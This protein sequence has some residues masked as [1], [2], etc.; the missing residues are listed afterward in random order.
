M[1]NQSGVNDIFENEGGGNKTKTILL[2]SIVAVILVVAFLIIAWVITREDTIE[3]IDAI[4]DSQ[5][6]RVI[7]QPSY[8]SNTG[9]SVQQYPPPYGGS[10]PLDINMSGISGTPPPSIP[11]L[12]PPSSSTDTDTLND[13][14]IIDTMRQIAS[15]DAVNKGTGGLDTPSATPSAPKADSM[16][17]KV[18]QAAAPAAMAPKDMPKPEAKPEVKDTPKDIK[19]TSTQAPKPLPPVK[20]ES[21]K[22]EAKTEAKP[23]K[24]SKETKVADNAAK[25]APKPAAAPGNNIIGRP[26]TTPDADNGKPATKGHYIQVGSFT[27]AV[28]SIFLNK[29][30]KYS[31]RIKEDSKDGKTVMKYLVGPYPSKVD[32]NKNIK[33]IKEEVQGSAFYLEIK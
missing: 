14:A 33:K 11:T 30:S 3:T 15:Q 32:A 25:P 26:A 13:P 31:Y 17:T 1:K 29:I 24:D 10:N 19:P 2:L 16:D 27:G 21:K 28:D 9:N 6:N 23:M 8:S 22:P 4:G 7:N 5:N 12:N 18:A 20:P